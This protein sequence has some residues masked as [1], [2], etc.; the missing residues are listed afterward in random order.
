MGVSTDGN[1]SISSVIQKTFIE[2]DEAGTKATAATIVQMCDE[3]VRISDTE[4]NL[5]RPFVYAIVDTETN[6]P[7]F[8]G[9]LNTLE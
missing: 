4:I 6:I 5:N 2:V 7:I 1:I 8:I 9:T 3:C